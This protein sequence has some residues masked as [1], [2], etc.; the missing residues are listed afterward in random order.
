MT[1]WFLYSYNS[2]LALSNVLFFAFFIVYFLLKKSNEKLSYWLQASFLFQFFSFFGLFFAFSSFFSWS[3]YFV[4]L[5]VFSGV[6]F[7]GYIQSLPTPPK[8]SKL[9]K[10]SLVLSIG[11]AIIFY[12]Y[13]ILVIPQPQEYNFPNHLLSL[14]IRWEVGFFILLLFCLNLFFLIRK[15]VGQKL[16]F[17]Y[18]IFS[19]STAILFL[20]PQKLSMEFN[21]FPYIFFAVSLSGLLV[22]IYSLEIAQE[23]LTIRFKLLGFCLLIFFCSIIIFSNQANNQFNKDFDNRKVSEIKNFA[24]YLVDDSFVDIPKNIEY[25]LLK[26]AFKILSS[27]EYDLL[28]SK[29]SLL[30]IEDIK[31]NNKESTQTETRFYNKP[32][33]VRNYRIS[34]S[35]NYFLY[36]TFIEQSDWYEIGYEYS[37]Y[38]ESLDEHTIPY[39]YS[40]FGAYICLIVVYLIFFHFVLNKP[41]QKLHEG[42]EQAE[43][44]DFD[45]PIFIDTIDEITSISQIFNSFVGNTKNLKNQ[46]ESYISKLETNIGELTNELKEKMEETQ[47]LKV[48]QDGDYFLTSLLAKPLSLNGNKSDFVIT[49]FIIKQKKEFVFRNRKGDIGGDVC[50][51]GN[52]K[53]GTTKKFKKY[54]VVMNGDAMGKSMQGAGGA[55]IAG[56]A[57]NSILARTSTDKKMLNITPEK[58]L[59][60]V[61]TELDTIFQSFNGSM[62][63][64][65]VIFLV[66]EESGTTWYFNAEHPFSVLYQQGKVRFIESSH[67][68]RKLGLESDIP[69]KI[70]KF[71]LS[72]GDIIIAGSDGRDDIYLKSKENEKL[73]N[74]DQSLFLQ[75]VKNAKADLKK[76]EQSILDS[77]SLIDD[78][79][80]VRLGYKEKVGLQSKQ[81]SKPSTE[82]NSTTNFKSLDELLLKGKK[83]YIGGD[84]NKAISLFM[85]AYSM[86]E[87]NQKLSKLLG[88]LCFKGKNYEVAVRILNQYLLQD[89]ETIDLWYYLSIAHK[90]LGN[91]LQSIEAAKKIYEVQPDNVFN[92]INLSDLYR[93][94]GK[95]SEA[96]FYSNKAIELDPENKNAR[97]LYKLLNKSKEPQVSP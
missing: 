96:R 17:S 54:T 26:P 69:F 81:D 66:E 29:K 61:Y 56:V 27:K 80:L 72:Q 33:Y 16:I 75:H 36:Y 93:R 35:G 34:K 49:D 51:T 47:K 12:L 65:M 46:R 82:Q 91:F 28:Y 58:W 83:L 53:L 22:F 24:P 25:I 85:E 52:L 41:L 9:Q 84:I 8:E 32:S 74:E 60:D 6:C 20:I 2:I 38:R 31:E 63:L 50:I 87:K 44:G 62:A 88:L 92:L 23:E 30:T 67:Q 59:E 21:L 86:D 7:L 15:L 3:I 5:V 71:Q 57:M 48:Q 68:V 73:M 97:K 11:L 77:G 13:L 64:S 45:S 39:L 94:I 89:P 70:Q 14:N 78:L 95:Y 79:S 37:K 55:L 42:V 43:S 40:T 18:I 90:R 10:L 76:I 1:E 19:L 4:Y